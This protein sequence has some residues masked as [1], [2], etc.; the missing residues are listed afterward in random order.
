MS[1]FDHF[2]GMALKGLISP[3]IEGEF[4]RLSPQVSDQPANNP[5]REWRSLITRL[6]DIIH[7]RIRFKEFYIIWSRRWNLRITKQSRNISRKAVD[8]EP[9]KEDGFAFT[10]QIRRTNSMTTRAVSETLFPSLVWHQKVLTI[11]LI[12]LR[13]IIGLTVINNHWIHNN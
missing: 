2:V 1:V 3:R 8:I 10:K 12:G 5:S 9:I 6:F 11:L 7:F 4:N 13:L